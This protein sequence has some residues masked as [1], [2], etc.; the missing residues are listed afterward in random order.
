MKPGTGDGA[1]GVAPGADM[2]GGMGA[3]VAGV[4][5]VA[6]GRR[7]DAAPGVVPAFV[8]GIAVPAEGGR[9]TNFQSEYFPAFSKSRSRSLK[10][11][12]LIGASA[13]SL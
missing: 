5:G 13:V 2:P 12:I 10:L 8:A 6:P 4:A 1:E 7:G 3:P 11:V 9:Y